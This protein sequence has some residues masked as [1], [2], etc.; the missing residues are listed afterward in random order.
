MWGSHTFAT[1]SS[2]VNV[3]VY[4]TDGKGRE[5]PSRLFKA[6]RTLKFPASTDHTTLHGQWYT[7]R[8][9]IP[10][11]VILGVQLQASYHAKPY[12]SCML[13]LQTRSTGPYIKVRAKLS[14]DS[15]AAYDWLDAFEGRADI[16]SLKE[17]LKQNVNIPPNIR[18]IYFDS[19]EIAEEFL[20]EQL[21]PA[22]ANKPKLTT[23]VSAAGEKK[24]VRISDG[25]RRIIRVR[26]K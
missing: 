8:I 26:N 14:V 25:P 22:A 12:A 17:A 23:V 7:Q 15:N 4:P 5:F 13:L 24:S 6:E 10:D 19:E 9:Q 18:K 2:K 16:I 3:F 20:V 21:L 1:S 11:D